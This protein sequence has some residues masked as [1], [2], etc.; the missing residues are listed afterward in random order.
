MLGRGVY[1]ARWQCAAALFA[2]LAVCAGK[3]R[4]DDGEAEPKTRDATLVAGLLDLSVQGAE[5]TESS[6]GLILRITRAL[7]GLDEEG[8]AERVPHTQLG[9]ELAL[10][11]GKLGGEDSCG[12]PCLMDA[13]TGNLV[14]TSNGP[15]HYTFAATGLAQF[16]LAGNDP[17]LMLWGGP[18]AGYRMTGSEGT[19]RSQ[20][21]IDAVFS[22]Y[23][24]NF[25]VDLSAGVAVPLAASP[26]FPIENGVQVR[27]GIAIGFVGW[28][29]D[30]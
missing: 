10:V 27:L 29:W 9:G 3:S 11:T 14:T 30:D 1:R 7:G 23:A 19:Q 25:V 17:T 8:R 28:W 2:S 15:T 18:R 12:D 4:A 6:Y 22:G 13:T 26:D 24:A 5:E 20:L 21:P 16:R